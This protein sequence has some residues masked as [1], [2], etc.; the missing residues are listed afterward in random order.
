[1][2]RQE[3]FATLASAV[4][5]LSKFGIVLSVVVFSLCLSWPLHKEAFKFTRELDSA[6]PDMSGDGA[7]GASNGF[8]YWEP[9]SVPR[10]AELEAADEPRAVEYMKHAIDQLAT[11]RNPVRLN[12]EQLD[13][14][15]L[16]VN[17]VR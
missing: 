8:I 17:H 12:T 7:G 2:G 16:V 4:L 6:V 14:L 10:L 5:L 1:M 13:F 15:A 11:G 3:L 9:S